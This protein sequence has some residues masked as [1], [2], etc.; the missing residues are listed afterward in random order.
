MVMPQGNAV[1]D[2]SPLHPERSDFS[3][4][5]RL[6]DIRFDHSLGILHAAH[7]GLWTPDDADRY[8]DEIQRILRLVRPI[9]GIVRM[10]SD[11]RNAPV[12]PADTG[13][14]LHERNMLVYRPTDRLALIVES[15]L[16][17]MQTRRLCLGSHQETFLSPDAAQTWVLAGSAATAP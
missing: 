3:S 15:S 9:T 11:M 16:L 2:V 13:S 4:M 17:K 14:R 5:S 6:W 8:V 12:R 1:Q 10:I 7:Y